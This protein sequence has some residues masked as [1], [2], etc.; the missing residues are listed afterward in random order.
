MSDVK[1]EEVT[2]EDVKLSAGDF[3]F[4]ASNGEKYVGMLRYPSS[5]PALPL[6]VIW[7]NGADSLYDPKMHIPFV[8]V[9]T[10]K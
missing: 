7:T 8:G 10:V 3:V 5:N 1:I 4:F 6:M 9:L 2:K